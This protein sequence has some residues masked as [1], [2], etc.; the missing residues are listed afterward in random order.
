MAHAVN[1]S[2]K[3]V[4]LEFS[5]CDTSKSLSIDLRRGDRLWSSRRWK[6]QQAKAVAGDSSNPYE[7]VCVG[8]LLATVLNPGTGFSFVLRI[9]TRA[10]LGDTLEA[11]SYR[12]IARLDINGRQINGITAGQVNVPQPPNP[13]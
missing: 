5:Q 1:A 12:V 8:G 2:S 10:V 13:R 6:I 3:G 7:I 9:P 11:G 4:A